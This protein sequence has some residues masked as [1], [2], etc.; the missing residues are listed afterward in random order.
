MQEQLLYWT[1]SRVEA[2]YLHTLS[3]E[4]TDLKYWKPKP[5]NI[6]LKDSPLRWVLAVLAVLLA[7]LLRFAFR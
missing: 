2:D 7:V 4:V 6:D 5:A 3:I 1:H